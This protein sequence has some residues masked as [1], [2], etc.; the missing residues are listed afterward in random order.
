MGHRQSTC[1]AG[2]TRT[3]RDEMN[4]RA[5]CGKSARTVPWRSAAQRLSVH[6][7]TKL[8]NPPSRSAKIISGFIKN[9]DRVPW[10]LRMEGPIARIAVAVNTF[11]PEF[12]GGYYFDHELMCALSNKLIDGN[13]ADILYKRAVLSNFQEVVSIGREMQK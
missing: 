12:K 4:R 9:V 1:A 5:A 3:S 10:R 8:T 2:A 13:S 11:Y 6:M 7:M